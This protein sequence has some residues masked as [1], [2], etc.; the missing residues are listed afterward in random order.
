MDALPRY[1]C[2]DTQMEL[3]AWF[4]TFLSVQICWQKRMT[5]EEEEEEDAAMPKGRRGGLGCPASAGEGATLRVKDS[6]PPKKSP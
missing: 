1:L 6:R 3:R 4:A 2:C 5:E